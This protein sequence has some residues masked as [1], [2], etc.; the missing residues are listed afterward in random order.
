MMHFQ[1]FNMRETFLFL[2]KINGN[3]Q[4]SLLKGMVIQHTRHKSQIVF[5]VFYCHTASLFNNQVNI[6]RL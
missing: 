3:L 6:V 5:S 2:S 4:Q 1:V